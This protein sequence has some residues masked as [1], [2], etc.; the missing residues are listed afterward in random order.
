MNILGLKVQ[1]LNV[2]E[3]GCLGAGLLAARGAEPA[4]PLAEVLGRTVKV[5]R[6]FSP[7][8]RFA[9]EHRHAYNLYQQ[10]YP[11]M[12]EVLHEI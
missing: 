6:S 4:F 5:E 7:D 10:L 8:K 12:H 9:D 11:R 3:T 2:L 1:R